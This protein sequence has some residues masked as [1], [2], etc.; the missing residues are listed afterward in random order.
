[1][2]L[3]K[4]RKNCGGDNFVKCNQELL[5]AGGLET[6]EGVFGGSTQ[7]RDKDQNNQDMVIVPLTTDMHP[8]RAKQKQRLIKME[9]KARAN[10]NPKALARIALQQ[11][12]VAYY[13]SDIDY[14]PLFDEGLSIQ[15]A[16]IRAQALKL[17]AIRVSANDGVDWIAEDMYERL[18][19]K[20]SLEDE[21]AMFGGGN[22][23]KSNKRGLVAAPHDGAQQQVGGNGNRRDFPHLTHRLN[24]VLA[25]LET[26]KDEGKRMQLEKR[27]SF[28]E[29]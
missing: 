27:K 9:A 21:I 18:P 23:N 10:K 4:E 19:E 16:A 6:T 5:G 22:E 13:P 24:R 26:V 2:S 14:V 28:L 17:A 20:W 3:H 29:T 7:E 1:M 12:Y 25:R 11:V 15:R 8:H